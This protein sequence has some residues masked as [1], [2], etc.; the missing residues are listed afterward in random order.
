M[1]AGG[2]DGIGD[3]FPADDL[4]GRINA[5]NADVSFAHGRG[6]GALG[7]EKPGGSALGVVGGGEF[8]DHAIDV[9]SAAGHGC[10]DDAIGERE[11][12]QDKRFKKSRHKAPILL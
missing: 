3:P 4:I 11:F 12:P 2:V 5:G 9:G 1:A 7:D 10:H 6:D 8:A